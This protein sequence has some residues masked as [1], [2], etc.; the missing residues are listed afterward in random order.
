VSQ[1]KSQATW[2][3]EQGWLSSS[4]DV[5]VSF[6]N[7]FSCCGLYSFNDTVAD[8]NSPIGF[9]PLAGLPCPTGLTNNTSGGCMPLLVQAFNSNYTTLS[10]FGIA[11]AVLMLIWMVVVCVLM[12]GIRAKAERG[13]SMHA[14]DDSSNPSGSSTT[15]DTT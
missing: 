13:E 12:R 11:V 3:V 6:E 8:P 7:A 5:R 1:K 2:L 15:V 10:N 14:G 4:N 9:S